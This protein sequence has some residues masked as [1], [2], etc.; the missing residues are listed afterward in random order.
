MLKP[1]LKQFVYMSADMCTIK[2]K[3]QYKLIFKLLKNYGKKRLN[4]RQL[5]GNSSGIGQKRSSVL[6]A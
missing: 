2:I 4:K 5:S 6:S 1:E 3:I